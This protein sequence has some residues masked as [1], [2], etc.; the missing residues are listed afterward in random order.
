MSLIFISYYEIL[1]ALGI[2]RAGRSA[3]P[4]DETKGAALVALVKVGQG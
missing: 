3:V 2:H 1:C 4:G